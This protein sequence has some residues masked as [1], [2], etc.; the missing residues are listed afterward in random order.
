MRSVAEGAFQ[1]KRGQRGARAQR[2]QQASRGGPLLMRWCARVPDLAQ[3]GQC[4]NGKLVLACLELAV[5]VT[6]DEE[7][8]AKHSAQI[9]DLAA[10]QDFGRDVHVADRRRAPNLSRQ[11]VLPPWH[12]R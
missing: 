9:L 3:M 6:H 11:G 1:K 12:T 2:P 10:G 7:Q 8:G 4:W 5:H